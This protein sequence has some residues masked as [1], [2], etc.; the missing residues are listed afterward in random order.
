MKY[1][2]L[3][4]DDDKQLTSFLIQL[5]IENGY[6]VEVAHDGTQ[7]LQAIERLTPDLVLLDLGLPDIR[8]ETV[9]QELK[10][11]FPQV[12]VI[13]LTA[14]DSPSDVAKG[15]NIGADDY[16]VKPFQGEELIARVRARL[17]QG[18]DQNSTLKID[19]LEV[20][21][22]RVEVK[23]GGKSIQ[24]TQ[25][26]FMLLE[27]LM[28]NPG[29]VLSREMILNR[30][31][32]YTPDIESRVVDVYVGYL[33]KKIDEPFSKKLIESVRGFGYTIKGA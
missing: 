17:R 30:V 33:R 7:A 14:F 13:M 31:W 6:G 29:K 20:D 22:E 5:L 2:I 16:I 23:R 12:P 28:R 24:L 1:T 4:V 21:T 3:V 15:L 26:E 25:R 11:L 19:D 27:Y 8:G 32:S 10:R 9:C 18:Q